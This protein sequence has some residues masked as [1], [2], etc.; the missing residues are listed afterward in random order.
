[1]SE[2]DTKFSCCD[3]M[4]VGSFISLLDIHVTWYSLNVPFS[5]MELYRKSYYNLR[6]EEFIMSIAVKE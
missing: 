1:M 2:I 4:P 6:G 5:N 3:G